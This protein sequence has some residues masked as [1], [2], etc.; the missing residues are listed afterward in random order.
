MYP[1]VGT[2]VLIRPAQT[3]YERINVHDSREAAPLLQQ[4]RYTYSKFRPDHVIC[5]AAYSDRALRKLIRRQYRAEP[6]IDPNP[7]HKKAV[8]LTKKTAEWRMIP[9]DDKET[10]KGIGVV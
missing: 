1:G 3:F 7:Q 6:I 2:F 5:D 8:G 10:G 4:A 9:S